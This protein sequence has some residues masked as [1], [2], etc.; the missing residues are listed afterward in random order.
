MRCCWTPKCGTYLWIGE[1]LNNWKLSGMFTFKLH[2][3]LGPRVCSS[4]HKNLPSCIIAY[5]YYTLRLLQNRIYMSIHFYIPIIRISIYI[6]RII[7]ILYIYIKKHTY[8]SRIISIYQ[9]SYLSRII[10]IY[11]IYIITKFPKLNLPSWHPL[12][13]N[14][15]KG[16]D[17]V[18]ENVWW[19]PQFMA[20]HG[21]K[22]GKMMGKW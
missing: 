3:P 8:I 16:M 21:E 12:T 7:S 2:V 11:R 6:P 15:P 1:P 19:R 20:L 13:P 4:L 17:L 10:S 22:D 9:E 18:P 5:H 14:H